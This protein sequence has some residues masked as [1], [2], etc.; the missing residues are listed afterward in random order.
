MT[1]LFS[2]FALRGVTFRNRI[3]VSP[4]CQY[5]CSEDGKPTDWHLAHLVS[6]AVSGVSLVIAEASAVTPEGRITPRDLGIWGDEHIRPHARLA[7][8]IA[9]VGAVPAI[10]LGHAGRKSSMQRP[11]EGNGPL[12]PKE[13]AKG[14][15]PWPIVGP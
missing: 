15:T 3:G 11:W 5:S 6:R 4:M 8:A 7:G 1:D 13:I 10:Q 14:E 9:A 2:P 12:G